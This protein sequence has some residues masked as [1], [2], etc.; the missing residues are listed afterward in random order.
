M[1]LFPFS[2]EKCETVKITATCWSGTG[3]LRDSDSCNNDFHCGFGEKNLT[4]SGSE[5]K[6]R[7]LSAEN[8]WHSATCVYRYIFRSRL[9]ALAKNIALAFQS[10]EGHRAVAFLEFA[11]ILDPLVLFKIFPDVYVLV[12]RPT[13]ASH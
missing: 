1:I 4:E 6:V 12:I 5:A 2:D 8:L 11:Q 13:Q 7:F 3:T 10:G 9:P